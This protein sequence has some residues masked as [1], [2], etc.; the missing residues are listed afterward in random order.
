MAKQDKLN[1]VPP[2][3]PLL[4]QDWQSS[5][6]VRTMTMTQQGIFLNILIHQWV[7]GGFPRSAW[8][9]SRRIGS[10]YK[11]TGRLLE[12]YSDLAVCCQCG[13]S[14]TPVACQ[15]GA[16]NLTATCHNPKLKNHRI[17]VDSDLALGTT[18]LNPTQP[19]LRE[20]HLASASPTGGG[21]EV[22][23][24]ALGGKVSDQ[25]T[26]LDPPPTPTGDAPMVNDSLVTEFVA[27]LGQKPSVLSRNYWSTVFATLVKEYGEPQFRNVLAYCF[28]NERYCRG[29]KTTARDKADWFA[30]KFPAIADKMTAD[31]E[32]DSKRSAKVASAKVPENAPD[33]RKNPTG[34][35]WFGKS[36]V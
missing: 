9:L 14:W 10:D 12:K 19:K 3:L 29:V 1:R 17:D 35:D 22:T 30:E 13:A 15:C 16:S 21:G 31:A 7:Y 24:T 34:R 27:L 23:S 28:A 2:F 6:S 4:W 11:S 33:Y 5:P 20:P 25:A 8:E 26:P 18:E 32:F 36:V